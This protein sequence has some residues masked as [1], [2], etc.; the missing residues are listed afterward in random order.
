MVEHE[1]YSVGFSVIYAFRQLLLNQYLN[2]T[3]VNYNI[4]SHNKIVIQIYWLIF[5]RSTKNSACYIWL[6]NHQNMG[7]LLLEN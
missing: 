6:P 5:F 3:H 7:K 2:K 4:V 1:T